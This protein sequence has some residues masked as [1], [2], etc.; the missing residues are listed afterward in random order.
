[1]SVDKVEVLR[2]AG[3]ATSLEVRIIVKKVV[4]YAMETMADWEYAYLA[5]GISMAQQGGNA[6][7][8]LVTASENEVDQ[9][10]TLGGLRLRPDATLRQLDPAEIAVLVLPGGEEWLEAHTAVLDLATELVDAGTPVAG[11]CGATLGLARSGLLDE[12]LH[13][14]NASWFLEGVPGYA[15][16]RHYRQERVVVDHDV[17]TAPGATPVDFARAIFERLDLLPQARLDAWYG[18]Y[19]TGDPKHFNDLYGVS[20]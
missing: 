11:I 5:A 7:Y 12:R 19:A 2:D 14:S 1:M 6:R 13:T 10:R 20:A 9:V 15:G 17:I 3:R 18:L 16:S 8:E 4:L